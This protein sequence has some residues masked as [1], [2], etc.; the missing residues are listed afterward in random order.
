[1]MTFF[2]L[3]PP[4]NILGFKCECAETHHSE[5]RIVDMVTSRMSA[6][7][8][9]QTPVYFGLCD[10]L[11]LYTANAVPRSLGLEF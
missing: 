4:S 9:N 6:D 8:L 7:L 3:R 11:S 5:R 2:G 1:M 10:E